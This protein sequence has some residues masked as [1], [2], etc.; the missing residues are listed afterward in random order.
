MSLGCL[1]HDSRD[2]RTVTPFSPRDERV[3]HCVGLVLAGMYSRATSVERRRDPRY[4]YP[5]LVRLW[6]LG[7]DG[8]T[9]CGDA[10]VVVGKDLSE[11]GIGFFHPKPI[12]HRL[13]IATLATIDQSEVELL[14]DLN[15]CR[16]TRQ[17]WYES[18]GRFVRAIEPNSAASVVAPMIGEPLA[19]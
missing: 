18:G 3:R 16:F 10:I 11:S 2:A 1:I 5:R 14:V 4:P 12:P 17:G 13:V 9:R 6:P 7:R 8:K 19:V 15:W